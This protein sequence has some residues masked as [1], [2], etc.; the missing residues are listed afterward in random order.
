MGSR[1]DPVV[2]KAPLR[3]SPDSTPWLASWAQVGH[4]WASLSLFI[5]ATLSLLQDSSSPYLG[6]GQPITTH[7]PV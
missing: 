3:V 5:K 6:L 2:P 4:L 7:S 1:P